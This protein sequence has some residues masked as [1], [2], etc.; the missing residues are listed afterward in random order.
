MMI[1]C[2]FAYEWHNVRT[3]GYLKVISW[4]INFFHAWCVIFI[5]FQWWH[6]FCC[7][8][9]YWCVFLIN[10]YKNNFPIFINLIILIGYEYTT[11]KVM[12]KCITC[13][14]SNIWSTWIITSAD[15]K[16]LTDVSSSNQN[17]L[18]QQTF[19]ISRL[20]SCI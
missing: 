16:I 8:C 13:K 19:D 6:L 2:N 4:S 11:C 3:M 7:C 20:N 12:F 18:W 1:L 9:F 14:C 17:L 5:A 10:S 15:I